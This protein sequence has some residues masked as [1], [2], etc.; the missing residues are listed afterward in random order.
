MRVG[1]REQLGI[2]VLL[3]SLVALA[4]V[5]IATVSCTPSFFLL[6]LTNDIYIRLVGKQLQLRREHQVRKLAQF[7]E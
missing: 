3:T 1:I 6:P 7:L 2:L 5:A 4:V